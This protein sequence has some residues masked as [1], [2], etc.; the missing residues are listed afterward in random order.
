ML[1]ILGEPLIYFTSKAEP[2]LLPTSLNDKELEVQKVKLAE[3]DLVEVTNITTEKD[4]QSAV[5]EYR[6]AYKNVNPFA[7]LH[8]TNFQNPIT[9]KAH[10]TKQKDEWQIG[11]SN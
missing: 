4:G 2:Y 3:E 9:R 11:M 6:T 8:K 7:A 1:K 5:V 10:F